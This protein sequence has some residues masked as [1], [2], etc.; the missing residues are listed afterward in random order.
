MALATL[1]GIPMRIDPN[2]IGWSFQMKIAE[3]S[4][5]GGKVIQVFGTDLGDMTISGVLGFGDRSK[6]DTAGW[7]DMERFRARV[8]GWADN[9]TRQLHP[10]PVRFLYPSKKWDFNVYVKAF[11]GVGGGP[12]EHSNVNYNPAFTLTLFVAED[13]TGVVV[14]GIQDRYIS[15]LMSGIGWKQTKY[16]GPTQ[17]QV[18]QTLA[19]YHGSV[20]D[21]IHQ[22]F[23]DA[24]NPNNTTGAMG[25]G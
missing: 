7:E 8:Q 16:N 3:H 13:A 12:I 17:Q 2:S 5:V 1:G 14:K 20:A 6:G 9:A 4:T 24:V 18:D 10:A 22:Q 19:P 21:Y 25:G 15:R 23:L 11:G